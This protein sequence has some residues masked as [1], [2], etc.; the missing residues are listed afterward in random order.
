MVYLAVAVA[1]V[2]AVAT[3]N[4]LL[5][6]GVIRRLREHTERLAAAPAGGGLGPPPDLMLPVGQRPGEFRAETV[7]GV[8]L[9]LAGLAAPVLLGFFSPLCEPCREW[10]P[11]FVQ[12]AAELPKGRAQALA[13]VVGDGAESGDEVAE[14]R[15]VAQV[16]VE[17]LD[18]PVSRAFGVRGWPA[19]CRVDADGFITT[20]DNHAA[21]AVPAAA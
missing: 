2:G 11:R 9:S 17:P 20:T 15:R 7:D 5:T 21:V 4:L 16:V 18:G 19:L 6:L 13:V 12:A 8:E 1:V 14:L 10:V 3:L